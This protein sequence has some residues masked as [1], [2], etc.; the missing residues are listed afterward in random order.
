MREVPFGDFCARC[1][2]PLNAGLCH[3]CASTDRQLMP[4]LALP[5]WL[6]LVG[7][8]RTEQKRLQMDK[9]QPSVAARKA[10]R[11]KERSAAK[12]EQLV[13]LVRDLGNRP[14]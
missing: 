8:S 9:N 3:R 10:M 1:A 12:R 14:T 5:A 13:E 2:E 7:L 11:R 6:A 4:L